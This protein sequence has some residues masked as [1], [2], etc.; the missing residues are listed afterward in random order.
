MLLEMK[1]CVCV[2][3]CQDCISSAAM[4]DVAAGQYEVVIAHPEALLCTDEGRKLL[5]NSAF[6]K[7]VVALVIDE[8][9]TVDLW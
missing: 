6:C 9:H 8:C 2:V 7:R 5:N 3:C 4:K 1:S